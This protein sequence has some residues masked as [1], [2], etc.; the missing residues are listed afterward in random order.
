MVDGKRQWVEFE[1]QQ[2]EDEDF[3]ALG[4]DFARDTGAER[5]G[6]VGWGE[7]RLMSVRT[8]VDYAVGW[9]ETHR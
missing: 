6:K 9:F 7:G 2:A 1:D 4:T 5:C 3:P 8:L